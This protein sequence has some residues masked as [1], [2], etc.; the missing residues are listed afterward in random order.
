VSGVILFDLDGTLVDADHLHYEAWR[1]SLAPMGIDLTTETYRNEIMGFPNE[2]IAERLFPTLDKS[3]AIRLIDGKEAMFRSFATRL[4]PAAG[5]VGFLDWLERRGTAAGVVTNAPRL[6]AEQE[7]LGIGLAER[8]GALVIGEE[9]EFSKP[10]PMPYLTGLERLGGVADRSLAFEDSLS[11]LR[12]AKAA[13]L[14]VIGVTTGLGAERLIAEG[15]DLAVADFADARLHA[16]CAAR[17]DG[18]LR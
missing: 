13:G 10:H 14:L 3:E 12:S 7:L 16:F 9:L 8:F 1:Q 17:L 4:E 18:V 2:M 6:N 5:L 11:G 15:A